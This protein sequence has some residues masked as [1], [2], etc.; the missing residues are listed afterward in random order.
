LYLLSIYN[1]VYLVFTTTYEAGATPRIGWKKVGVIF[2][3]LLSVHIFVQCKRKRVNNRKHVTS[4]TQQHVNNNN[5]NHHRLDN[6]GNNMGDATA[7]TTTK[8]GA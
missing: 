4:L 8:T 7:A 1:I 6:G 5:I 2:I 3:T